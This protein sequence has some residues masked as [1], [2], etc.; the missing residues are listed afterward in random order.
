MWATKKAAI[1]KSA[2]NG[3]QYQAN[4]RAEREREKRERDR[5]RAVQ[6]GAGREQKVSFRFFRETSVSHPLTVVLADMLLLLRLLLLRLR[7][8]SSSVFFL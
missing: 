1:K 8:S 5:E 7:P 2:Q 4:L 3:R 6:R